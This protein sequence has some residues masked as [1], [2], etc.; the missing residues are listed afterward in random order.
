MKGHK[1]GVQGT[2]YLAIHESGFDFDGSE[3]LRIL[4]VRGAIQ[5]KG[6][7]VVGEEEEWGCPN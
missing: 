4:I 1:H 7:N 2:W 5:K 6:L 3:D